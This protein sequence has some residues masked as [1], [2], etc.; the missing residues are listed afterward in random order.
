MDGIYS[1]GIENYQTIEKQNENNDYIETGN[2]IPIQVKEFENYIYDILNKYDNM[3][4]Q[5]KNTIESP[6]NNPIIYKTYD[7]RYVKIPFDV[8]DT[9]I[10]KW[11]NNKQVKQQNNN[12]YNIPN[13]QNNI[14]NTQNIPNMSDTQNIQNI[15]N[16]QDMPNMSDLQNKQN[17]YDERKQ[18]TLNHVEHFNDQYD[19]D[20]HDNYNDNNGVNQQYN[21]HQNNGHNKR[22]HKG[23]HRKPH[24]NV[25]NNNN[26]NND[27]NFES[28]N[29]MYDNTDTNYRHTQRHESSRQ[30]KL[31]GVDPN[32]MT[33]Q[34]NNINPSHNM[35]QLQNPHPRIISNSNE[36]IY[37][38][39]IFAMGIII[40][41]MLYQRKKI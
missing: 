20:Y 26:D 30:A 39:I 5:E 24:K 18:H 15:Q 25:H 21:V 40:V 32:E 36:N 27:N 31:I 1:N 14:S 33:S 2:D 13:T 19:N 11:I 37:K 12:Q 17:R 34:R 3:S 6:Y 9:S 23:K 7:G 16:I 38:I 8:Q 28:Q 4:Q 10:R 35:L 22:L 29:K 41:W